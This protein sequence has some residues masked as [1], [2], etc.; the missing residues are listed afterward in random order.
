MGN[1]QADVFMN[2]QRSSYLFVSPSHTVS[3]WLTNGILYK[4]NNDTFITVTDFHQ[5]TW[6]IWPIN[7]MLYKPINDI[8]ITVTDFTKPHCFFNS[9]D[10][11]QT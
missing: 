3:Y 10:V 1:I 8:F 9:I 2:C 4:P 6:F 11:V 7:G 5:A